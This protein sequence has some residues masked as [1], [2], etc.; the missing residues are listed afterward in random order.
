MEAYVIASP[1]GGIPAALPDIFPG[2]DGKRWEHLGRKALT[3]KLAKA[4][5]VLAQL[6]AKSRTR[7]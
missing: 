4:V 3:G 6:V 5:A 1:V 2:C 7:I